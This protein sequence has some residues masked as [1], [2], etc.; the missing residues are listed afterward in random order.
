[1]KI[2]VLVI[3]FK[4]MHLKNALAHV[5]KLI[6]ALKILIKINGKQL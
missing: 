4:S 2:W 5:E 1:M 3:F 6:L